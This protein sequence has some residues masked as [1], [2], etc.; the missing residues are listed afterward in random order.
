MLWQPDGRRQAEEAMEI[1]K[2]QGL[3][4][5]RVRC[6]LNLSVSSLMDGNPEAALRYLSEAESFATQHQIGRR[7][8]RV[9]A[10]LATTHE[11]CGQ[12]ERARARD[13]QT[14]TSLKAGTWEGDSVLQRGRNLLPLIN[15]AFRSAL[16]PELYAPVLPNG[17]RPET[18]LIVRE[19]AAKLTAGERCPFEGILLKYLVELGGRRRFLLTE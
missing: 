12:M 16:A 15:I 19:V 4:N 10:N 2:A 14:L 3:D 5:T 11:L 13:L 8:W 9:Y 6:D 17:V 7:L 18:A 1:A